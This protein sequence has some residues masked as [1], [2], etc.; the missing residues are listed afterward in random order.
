MGPASPEPNVVKTPK[1]APEAAPAAAV[2]APH[3]LFRQV[4]CDRP[5]S[6]APAHARRLMLALVA[7][8]L[9]SLADLICTLIYMSSV[10]LIELNPLARFM[11]SV[12]DTR[13]LVIFKLFTMTLSCGA[14][15]FARR[16]PL[17]ERVAWI[18]AAGL[19]VLMLHW[20]AFNSSV[21]DLTNEITTLALYG[22]HEWWV[23]L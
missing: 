23:R 9:M 22:G 14:L 21:S 6:L 5:S 8:A 16:H 1:A 15:Y 12:G 10:G 19:F 4:I 18:C 2:L 11:V 20:T 3:H 7:I 13:Q 17:S